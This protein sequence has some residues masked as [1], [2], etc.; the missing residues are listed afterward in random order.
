M[1]LERVLN[2]THLEVGMPH[3]PVVTVTPGRIIIDGRFGVIPADELRP[4]HVE[5]GVQSL[6]EAAATFAHHSDEPF[7]RAV[8][9]WGR[10]YTDVQESLAFAVAEPEPGDVLTVV[11]P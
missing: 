9:A 5:I 1:L 8:V 2:G 3:D 4:I 10:L 7:P 6:S 11:L